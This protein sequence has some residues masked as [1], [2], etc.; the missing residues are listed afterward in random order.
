MDEHLDGPL[1]EQ[2]ARRATTGLQNHQADINSLNVFP[3]P[4]SDTGTNMALTM[5]S[6]VRAMDEVL[7]AAGE[8]RSASL[9]E[10]TNALAKGAVLGARGNS[11]L[12]LSQVLRAL[13]ESATRGPIDGDALA[14]MLAHASDFAREAIST[15]VEGTVISVLAA[16]AEG[17]QAA[18]EE[19]LS[20]SEIVRRCLDSAEVALEQT[21]QHLDVLAQAGVV[22][23]GGK[24]FVVMM[25]ALADLVEGAPELE[26]EVQPHAVVQQ[27]VEVMFA[28][29]SDDPGVRDEMRGILEDQGNSV[30]VGPIS[31]TQVMMH[32]HTRHAGPIIEKA[33]ALGR[34]SGLRIEVLPLVEDAT[35]SPAA[36]LPIIALCPEPGD[37]DGGVR[38]LFE[39]LG[40]QTVSSEADIGRVLASAHEPTLVLLNGQDASLV[41]E[42]AADRQLEFI[43][44]FSIVGGL[45]A[46]AVF[47]ATADWEDTVDDIITAVSTQRTVHPEYQ[48]VC[49][50]LPAF[51]DELLG[52]GGELMTLLWDGDEA[53]E[54]GVSRAID[55]IKTHHEGLELQVI[56]TPGLG[57]PVE[58]GVE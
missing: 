38:E 29:E 22:D 24:G 4:D 48:V 27:E 13:A 47:D 43:E 21:P 19:S 39:Q 36:T 6:A 45:A 14:T 54:A 57:L 37:A 7:E 51:M 17:A 16:A 15:P 10:V 32:V 50:S 30:V 8:E 56:H 42:R 28:F 20:F 1:I 5:G 18:V 55:H 44:T 58:I 52:D 34:V 9:V 23:A 49:A 2:W 12:V 31:A 26:H 46:V 41:R 53:V 25:Q 33:F 40:A 11:G 35:A 3:I